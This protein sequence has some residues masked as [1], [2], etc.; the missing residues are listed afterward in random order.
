MT[1]DECTAWPATRD[2]AL[3]SLEMTERWAKRSKEHLERLHGDPAEA[4][5]AG[6]RIVNTGQA[7]FGINQGSVY[8]DLRQ[9]SLEGL[10]EIGFDGYAIGGLS[11][12]EDKNV[13]L[14]VVS[15]IAPKLPPDSPRYLMGVGTPEDIVQAVALGVDMF[16][17][18]MPTRNA[19]NGQLFTGSGRMNITNAR[20]REDPRPVDEECECSVCARYSRAYLRHLHMSGEITAAILNSHHN[21]SFYL[22]TMK[23]IRQSIELGTF[24]EFSKSFLKDLARGLD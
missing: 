11:V 15:H 2:E 12:G 9:R 1:F 19:R 18:V 4:E 5:R 8:L 7:L 21:I 10:V 16:D 6:L 3:K 22:D 13:M 24:I 14:E 17:C 20:Y 23:R